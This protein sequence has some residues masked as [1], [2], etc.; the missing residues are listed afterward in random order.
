[1]QRCMVG[2]GESP[3]GAHVGCPAV[4]QVTVGHV[5]QVG[6]LPRRGPL[7]GEPPVPL[8]IV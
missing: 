4:N 2:N 5:Q 1:M 7:S 3:V 8:P 6:D